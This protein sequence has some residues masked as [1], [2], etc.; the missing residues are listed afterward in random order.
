MSTNRKPVITNICLEFSQ[1]MGTFT[2]MFFSGPN[3]K[4]NV[5]R[6]NALSEIALFRT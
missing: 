5:S 1:P 6:I 2:P 4:L 3:V